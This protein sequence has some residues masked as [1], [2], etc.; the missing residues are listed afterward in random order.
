MSHGAL[1]VVGG[2]PPHGIIGFD[3]NR[4][5]IVT[6]KHLTKSAPR[7]VRSISANPEASRVS[8][9]RAAL[10]DG[11]LALRELVVTVVL[12]RIAAMLKENRKELCGEENRFVSD[13]TACRYGHDKGTV[14]F[15]GKKIRS[16]KP[17]VRIV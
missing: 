10:L 8:A 12:E 14:V 16:R 2:P 1:K 4:R 7:E 6:G 17:R 11:H 13:R 9:L 15:V 3:N 5:T